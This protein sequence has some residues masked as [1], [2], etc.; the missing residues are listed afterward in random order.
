[1]SSQPPRLNENQVR[2]VLAVLSRVDSLLGSVEQL[3]S[4]RSSPFDRA[5]RDLATDETSLM[6]NF[7]LEMRSRM[8]KALN[9]LGIPAPERDQSARWAIQA[10]L[11]LADVALTDMAGRGLEGYG[12][13]NSFA[14]DEVAQISEEL[15][16]LI[17]K[18]IFLLHSLS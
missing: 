2:H 15:R 11:S 3:A 12:Q 16:E 17:Q 6:L 8:I 5:L 10:T 9:A 4:A 1:V 14:A 18:G 7:V 13:L